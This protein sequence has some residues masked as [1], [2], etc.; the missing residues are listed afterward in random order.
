MSGYFDQN[1]MLEANIIFALLFCSSQ[2][3]TRGNK[4]QPLWT[5]SG[6][7][8]FCKIMFASLLYGGG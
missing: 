5:R 3:P 4:N 8:H 6:K 7:I 2:Q 1:A